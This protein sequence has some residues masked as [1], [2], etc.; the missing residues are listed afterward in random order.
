MR[1]AMSPSSSVGGP[2]TEKLTTGPKRVLRGL[3]HTGHAGHRHPLHD[4]SVGAKWA[5]PLG[6]RGVGVTD[7]VGVH[8]VGP[9]AGQPG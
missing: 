1:C 6:Q 4:E 3:Q 7:R 8:E 5:E 2:A 9:D